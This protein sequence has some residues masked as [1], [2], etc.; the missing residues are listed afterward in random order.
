MR[1]PRR[2]ANRGARH[3]PPEALFYG[4][5][6]VDFPESLIVGTWVNKGVLG[7]GL[8]QVVDR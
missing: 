7:S 4:A 8:G 2:Q 1:R 5:G 6:E 3:R